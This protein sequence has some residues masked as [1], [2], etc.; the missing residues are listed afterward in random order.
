M[1]SFKGT[2]LSWN[3]TRNVVYYVFSGKVVPKDKSCKPKTVYI[4]VRYDDV[5]IGKDGTSTYIPS[6]HAARVSD[7]IEYMDIGGWDSVQC[8]LSEQNMFDNC[9]QKYTDRYNYEVSDDLKDLG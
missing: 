6:E 1:R 9:V 7:G 5:T 2:E 8:Y 3:E 4:A